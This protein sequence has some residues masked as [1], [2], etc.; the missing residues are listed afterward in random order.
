MKIIADMHTHTTASGHAYSSV[1]EL[2]SAAAV[3]GLKALAITDHGP[4]LPGGPHLYHFGAMRFIPREIA[5]VRI[6]LGCEANITDIAGGI[7]L[8]ENYL[9]KLDFIIAGFHE[10]CG[11]DSQGIA[12]NTEAM[13]KAMHNPF[14]HAISH[15]GN[16]VFTRPSMT[17]CH[18]LLVR[19]RIVR[20]GC[21][22]QHDRPPARGRSLP[23]GV[24]P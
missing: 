23:Q 2:A 6:L 13:I 15:P 7:D 17:A 20:G 14:I 8:P 16:P 18:Q 24:V 4:A 10:F 9:Q 21:V 3:K 12:R 5:G 19:L 1:N 22:F 11:F